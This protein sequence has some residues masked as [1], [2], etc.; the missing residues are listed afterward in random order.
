MTT[1]L[2]TSDD[3]LRYKMLIC[4]Y[5]IDS[6]FSSSFEGFVF[7]CR[8]SRKHFSNNIL[9]LFYWEVFFSDT[10]QC[11]K[12]SLLSRNRSVF[13]VETFCS[14]PPGSYSLFDRPS[15]F[16]KGLKPTQFGVANFLN[17][18]LKVLKSYSIETS[19]A[20]QLRGQ[21][22]NTKPTAVTVLSLCWLSRVNVSSGQCQSIKFF[23][24]FIAEL[25]YIFWP[26]SSPQI[27][28]PKGRPLT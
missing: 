5:W 16:L 12:I 3:L 25:Y 1:R 15:F 8:S 24:G 6:L 10:K 22:S 11:R 9:L 18:A 7:F 27:E 19:Q 4:N 26:A 20:R 21:H 14:F 23:L 13:L 2:F 28:K 17:R